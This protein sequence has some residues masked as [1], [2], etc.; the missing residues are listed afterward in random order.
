LDRFHR[1]QGHFLDLRTLAFALTNTGYTLARACEDFDVEHPKQEAELHGVIDPDYI[2]YNRTDV[3]ATAELFTKLITE[4]HR[5][6]ITLQ[7]T[8]AFSPASIGKAYL[9]AMG[10][11]PPLARQPDFPTDVLGYDSTHI[12]SRSSRTVRA[13]LIDGTR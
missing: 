1:F 5:H 8:K 13:P 10:I 4:Y 9:R 12:L 11:Q 7:P 6:P 2:T 3:R